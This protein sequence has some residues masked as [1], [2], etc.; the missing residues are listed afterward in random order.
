[1]P[2]YTLPGVYVEEI[3][4]QPRPIEDVS[5]STAG[6]AG[7][8]ERG[9]LTPRLVTSWAE[10]LRWYGDYVDRVVPPPSPNVFLPYAVRS[11]FENGGRRLHVARVTGA[12]SQ[13][14]QGELPA[15]DGNTIVAAS[16]PGDWGNQIVVL[17][18]KHSLELECFSV[19]VL[20]FRDGIP[21]GGPADR[22]PDALEEFKD[23]TSDRTLPNYAGAVINDASSL[24][25]IIDC[26]SPPAEALW[27]GIVLQGGLSE[28]AVAAEYQTGLAGLGEIEEIALMAIPDEVVIPTLGVAL[29]EQ[30]ENRRDRFAVLSE[31]YGQSDISQIRPPRDTSYGAFYYPMLRVPAPHTPEGRILVP[32]CGHVLGLIARVEMGR[33][34]AK[35]PADEVVRGIVESDPVQFVISKSEQDS[36]NSRGVN[37]VRDFRSMGRGVRVWGARTMS[38]DP[39]WRYI[40]VRRLCIFLERSIAHG[41][42]W[43]VFEPNSEQ[44]WSAVRASVHSFLGMVWRDGALQGNKEEQAFFVKCDHTTMTQDNIDNGR[45][46]CVIGVAPV[47]PAEFV[48]IR[49]EQRT[50]EVTP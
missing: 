11:F 30:C 24:I 36:L 20:Y 34:V 5:T 42:Q 3:W 16:G 48:I 1:M 37:V 39:E 18:T 4:R 33:G 35:A 49:I 31:A 38:S 6:M 40:N 47:K 41:T 28:P 22:E 23:L 32:P 12:A 29:I 46:I 8:T 13:T 44:T 21:A 50:I 14:A 15:A 10:Y 17:V 19:Q 2:D 7:E 43:T 25:R 26:P 45:L 9:P 27:P